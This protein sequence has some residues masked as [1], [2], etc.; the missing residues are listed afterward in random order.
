MLPTSWTKKITKSKEDIEIVALVWATG[1][2]IYTKSGSVNRTEQ[3]FPSFSG[4]LL[5]W[6]STVWR[7][8]KRCH[9]VV[10]EESLPAQHCGAHRNRRQLQLQPAGLGSLVFGITPTADVSCPAHIPAW[11]WPYVLRVS[12]LKLF[13]SPQHFPSLESPFDLLA[14]VD[15]IH[16]STGLLWYMIQIYES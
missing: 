1:S 8:E 10:S 7:M 9:A 15:P 6:A 13:L 2:F 12:E 14:L 4:H 16:T 3:S 11:V 5:G